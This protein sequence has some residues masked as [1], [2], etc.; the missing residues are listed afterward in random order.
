MMNLTASL[1]TLVV[2]SLVVFLTTNS[3]A[4]SYDMKR[5]SFR[6]IESDELDSSIRN[7]LERY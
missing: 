2:Y 7:M 4:F 5:F 1:M 3:Y 6:L